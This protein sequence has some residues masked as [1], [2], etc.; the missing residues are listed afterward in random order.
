MIAGRSVNLREARRRDSSTRGLY[1]RSIARLSADGRPHLLT[2]DR[3]S[4]VP[5]THAPLCLDCRSPRAAARASGNV[6]AESTTTLAVVAQRQVCGE[7]TPGDAGALLSLSPRAR[8]A[9]TDADHSPFHSALHSVLQW[10]WNGRLTGACCAAMAFP[11]T[12]TQPLSVLKRLPQPILSY[13]HLF[14]YQAPYYGYP[15]QAGMGYLPGAAGYG[16]GGYAPMMHGVMPPPYYAE[17]PPPMPNQPFN[18]HPGMPWAQG[19]PMYGADMMNMAS[20]AN[21]GNMAAMGPMAGPMAGPMSPMGAQHMPPYAAV[22]QPYTL[23]AP[24]GDAHGHDALHRAADASTVVAT[25]GGAAVR[26]GS[27][28]RPRVVGEQEARLLAFAARTP[29]S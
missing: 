8:L 13:P 29:R 24:P 25:T 5:L 10:R 27:R 20:A 11:P 4:I 21:M 7:S 17:Y 15:Q 18:M 16:S 28:A 19:M 9:T 6:A 12:A 26:L 1:V 22:H 2:L 23:S 14:T 3:Y